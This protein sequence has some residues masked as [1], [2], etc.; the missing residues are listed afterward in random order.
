M[1]SFVTMESGFKTSYLLSP[2]RF[3]PERFIPTLLIPKREL[4]RKH[5]ASAF[6]VK[7]VELVPNV[8]LESRKSRNGQVLAEMRGT[9]RHLSRDRG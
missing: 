7:Y 1:Y 9:C 5:A 3:R 4:L 6:T 2:Q 8:F